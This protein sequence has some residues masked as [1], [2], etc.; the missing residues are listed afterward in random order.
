MSPQPAGRNARAARVFV[1]VGNR[2][3]FRD[4]RHFQP[5]ELGDRLLTIA[6]DDGALRRIAAIDEIGRERVDAALKRIEVALVALELRLQLLR[7]PDQYA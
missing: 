2:F 7:R 4:D 1:E 3:L 6:L 5:V